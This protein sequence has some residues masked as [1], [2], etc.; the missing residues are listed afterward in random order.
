[1]L[2]GREIA[3]SNVSVEDQER[4]GRITL[5]RVVIGLSVCLCHISPTG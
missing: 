1:M 5:S 4:D 2:A 3:L